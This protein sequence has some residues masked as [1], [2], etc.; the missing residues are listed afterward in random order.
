MAAQHRRQIL[1]DDEAR[2]D[3]AAEAEHQGEQPDDPWRRR[4][5]GEDD[6]ELG[7]IDL[8]LLA[9]RGLEADL[10]A[11]LGRGRTDVA[12]EIGDRRVAAAIAELL[13]F[14]EQPPA[15]KTG[16]VA[17]RARADRP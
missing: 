12:Q 15:G 5:V 8:R 13:Q 2:P 6:M 14:P 7:E 1:M 10:V 3:Q 16:I 17:S 9:G 4:L 11:V